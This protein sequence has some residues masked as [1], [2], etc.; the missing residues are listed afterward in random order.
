MRPL[1]QF[2][3]RAPEERRLLIKA[4]LLLFAVRFG[5]FLLPFRTVARLLGRFAQP[6]E[7][8]PGTGDS[9]R[10]RIV[11]AV[12]RARTHLPG[13]GACLP[14]ALVG[15]FL[16]RRSGFRARLQIGVRK[17]DGGKLEAHAWV[18]HQGEVILGGSSTDIES[19]MALRNLD[20]AVS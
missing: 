7:A 14:E 13:T 2:L 3:S 17:G 20:K 6:R 12:T 19:F 5:L 1:D 16:L 4:T 18:E 10:D 9:Q 11:W 15:H 8:T